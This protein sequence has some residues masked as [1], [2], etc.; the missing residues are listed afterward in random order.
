MLFIVSRLVCR[1]G[2]F[3]TFVLITFLSIPSLI[4]HSKQVDKPVGYYQLQC[5]ETFSCPESLVPRVA[6]WVE[7]FSRWDTS[8]AIFHDKDNPHRVFS[9]VHRKQGCRKSRRG[10]SVYRERKRLEKSFKNIASRLKK[11][12]GT[13]H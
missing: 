7:V 12:K 5:D 10:D 8:T 11:W 9:T 1:R 13:K 3:I 6:F 4:V 2:S